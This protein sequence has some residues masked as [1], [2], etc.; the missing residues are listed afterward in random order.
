[1]ASPLKKMTILPTSVSPYSGRAAQIRLQSFCMLYG[2]DTWGTN[3]KNYKMIMM[4]MITKI[5]MMMLNSYIAL[6]H[7]IKVRKAEKNYKI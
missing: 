2:T 7:I 1:M 5:I 4:M 3:V 6:Y